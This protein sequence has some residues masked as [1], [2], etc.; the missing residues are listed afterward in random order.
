MIFRCLITTK[1]E[2]LV[3]KFL[4]RI[5]KL[6]CVAN[7]CGHKTKIKGTIKFFGE[8]TTMSMPLEEN[9][10]PDYCL[11][12]ISKMSIKCA[13]CSKPILIGEP[14]T[15]YI[16]EP[17]FEIPSHAKTFNHAEGKIGL[18]GCLDIDCCASGADVQGRWMPPGEVQRVPSPIERLLATP[19][20]NTVICNDLSKPEEVTL[21]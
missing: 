7:K 3:K 18:V 11:E 1:K 19:S 12:C 20:A 8:E 2:R 5:L 14:I 9:G 10:N 4:K 16:P 15:L 13:W 6:K 21:M 17:E